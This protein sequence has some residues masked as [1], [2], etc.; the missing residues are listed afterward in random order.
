MRRWT[1]YYDGVTGERFAFPPSGLVLAIRRRFLM[2][3]LFPGTQARLG[4]PGRPEARVLG[5][6]R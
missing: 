3:W 5:A 4:R 1:V 2:G 6:D